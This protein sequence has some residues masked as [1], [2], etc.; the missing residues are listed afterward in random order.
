MKNLIEALK[1]K[2]LKAKENGVELEIIVTIDCEDINLRNLHELTIVAIEETEN[3]L[4]LIPDSNMAFSIGKN[5][6]SIDCEELENF[7]YEYTIKYGNN[8]TISI[9]FF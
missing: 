3:T 6:E 1:A 2:G 9:S 4:E 8:V 7:E 5:Y